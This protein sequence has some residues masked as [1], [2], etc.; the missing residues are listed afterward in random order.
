MAREASRKPRWPER[1]RA[2]EMIY[3]LDLIAKPVQGGMMKTVLATQ[4]H[5]NHHPPTLTFFSHNVISRE[6]GHWRACSLPDIVHL[7]PEI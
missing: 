6:D 5:A 1:L 7:R 4:D 2:V 3:S